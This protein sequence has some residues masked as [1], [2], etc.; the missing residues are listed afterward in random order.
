M[1]VPI[2]VINLDRSADRLANITQTFGQARMPFTRW[3]AVDGTSV[4]EPLRRYFSDKYPLSPGE[5]GCYAS[6][7]AIWKHMV[8]HHI[9]VALICED[10]IA[11]PE[12]FAATLGNILV[13]AASGWEVIKLS[14]SSQ[15]AICPLRSVDQRHRLVRY[16]RI[17]MFTGA[18]LL[19][20]VGARKLLA[21]KG[22]RHAVDGDMARP[23]HFANLDVL[24]VAP[25]PIVQHRDSSI[26]AQLGGH[27]L[28]KRRVRWRISCERASRA[29]YNL[30]S[31]GLKNWWRCLVADHGVRR[32]L[33]P[34][35][36]RVATPTQKNVG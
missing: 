5:M 12:D 11:L 25:A 24:G 10:D 3:P 7:I 17:P 36:I 15:R 8:A 26:I 33:Q 21:F 28:A 4:P 9:G 31:M 2:F 14:S 20:L 18:Y 1:P 13:A 23:W 35:A 22:P 19:S 30:Q 6:H 27:G 29:H 34:S 16:W 32:Y